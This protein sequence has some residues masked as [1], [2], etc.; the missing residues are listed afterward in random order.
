M[1]SCCAPFASTAPPSKFVR[2]KRVQYKLSA[3]PLLNDA[4]FKETEAVV[5]DFA[6]G[7]GAVLH[8]QLSDLKKTK[9]RNSSYISEPWFDMYL[10]NRSPVAIHINPAV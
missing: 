4:E 6:K 1:C 8:Q 3:R 5:D 7:A 9:Y 10:E 2:Q